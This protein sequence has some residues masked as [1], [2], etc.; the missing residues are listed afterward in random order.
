MRF[1]WSLL[2][3]VSI[4]SAA[5]SNLRNQFKQAVFFNNI[6]L[7]QEKIDVAIYVLNVDTIDLKN[8]IYNADFL[9]YM[10]DSNGN[11]ARGIVS[12]FLS[13]IG[14]FSKIENLTR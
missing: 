2:L 12:P 10:Y 4:E 3:I 6:S 5:L 8:G 9:L 14:R 1:I 11:D 7:C 13:N